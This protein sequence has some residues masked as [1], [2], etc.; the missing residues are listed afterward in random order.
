MIEKSVNLVLLGLYRIF[1]PT[2]YTLSSPFIPFTLLYTES[3]RAWSNQ[4]SAMC[5]MSILNQ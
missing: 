5:L 2:F 3:I 4:G 1:L